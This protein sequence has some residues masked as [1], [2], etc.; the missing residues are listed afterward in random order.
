[1]KTVAILGATGRLGAATVRAFSGWNVRGLAH[2]QPHADEARPAM[3]ILGDRRDVDAVRHAMI[4]ADVVVDVLAFTVPGV[5]VVTDALEGLEERPK[6]LIMASTTAIFGPPDDEY[7]AGKRDAQRHY[8]AHFDGITHTL[9]LPRLVS[10]VDYQRR[11]QDY[12]NTAAEGNVMVGGDPAR[13][14]VIAPVDGVARVIRALAENPERVPAGRLNVGPPEPVTIGDAVEALVSGAG[15]TAKLV[16]HPDSSWRGPTGAVKNPSTPLGSRRCCPSLSGKIRWTSTGPSE[17]GS[18]SK[19]PQ[20]RGRSRSSSRST[21]SS[22]DRGWSTFTARARCPRSPSRF[23]P[24]R[25]SRL[26]SPR[27]STSTPGAHVTLPASTAQ[28]P[29]T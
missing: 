28:S 3:L 5:R 16:R 18:P 27:R 29:L 14:Q 12:L 4:G 25:E 19:R 8:E 15:F 23:P 9:V 7:G 26:G 24:S 10:P 17:S 2:R 11:E 21:R 22:S 20:R 13:R 6:H 1:M